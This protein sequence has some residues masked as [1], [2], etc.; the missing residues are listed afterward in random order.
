MS[1]QTIPQR[2][3]IITGM[4]CAA[5][6]RSVENDVK[7]LPFA[8]DA[9]VD[10]MSGALHVQGDVSDESIKSAV[11]ALGYDVGSGTEADE[12]GDGLLGFLGYVWSRPPTRMALFGVPFIIPGLFFGELFGREIVWAEWL[13]LVAAALAGAPVARSAWRA[14][15]RK[16]VDVHVLMTLAAVG[17]VAIGAW[18]EAGMVM[19]LYAVGVAVEGYVGERARASIRSL[20]L[21]SPEMA[22]RLRRAETPATAA[23]DANAL[24]TSRFTP[25]IVLKAS[26]QEDNVPEADSCCSTTAA[27]S[28]LDDDSTKSAIEAGGELIK[29]EALDVGDIIL[30][31][32]GAR[33]PV[34][35][36]VVAGHSGVDAAII[37]GESR[38][39]E[40]GPGDEVFAGSI[41]GE[42]SLEIEVTRPASD[43]T[44]RRV[45]RLVESAR[46]Q[47]APV[48][49]ALDRFA[50]W[51]TPAVVAVAAAVIVI[52]PL[53]FGQPLFDSGP[54]THG[55]LYRGLA[56]L[57]V[58]CPCALVLS[59]PASVAAAMSGAARSGILFK[60]GD[61]LEALAR[62]KAVAFDKT[63]TLTLGRPSVV[64]VRAADC[65]GEVT[66]NSKNGGVTVGADIVTT[67]VAEAAL[68]LDIALEMVASTPL[69]LCSACDE[70]VALAG[71][72]E[73]R[74]EHVL[75]RAVVN[76]SRER[77]VAGRYPTVE[78]VRAL[79]GQG[80]RGLVGEREVTVGSHR[81]FDDGVPHDSLVC[82]AAD[83]D[84]RMGA[85]PLLVSADGTYVGTITVADE[86]RPEARAVIEA[87]EKMGLG[88]IAMLTGDGPDAARRI[89]EVSGVSPDAVRASLMP[90]DKLDVIAALQR[91]VGSVA[92]IG[93]GV[94][95]APALAAADVGL[96]VG[97]GTDTA[98][99]T[100][101][102]ALMGDDLRQLP[103]AILRA[104]RAMRIVR[105]NIGISLGVKVVFGVLVLA[106]VGTLW[107]AVLADVGT[108]VIVT[109]NGLRAANVRGIKNAG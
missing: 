43:S 89:A 71:A 50:R 79:T 18:V 26:M 6:A 51:Y 97:Q 20:G 81:F 28:S 13:A 64:D 22:I 98:L 40:I 12:V 54:E 46:A 85:I 11:R 86:P 57:V 17:A 9:S 102:V 4:D 15:I 60:G 68:G 56:L 74:S 35:G 108:A 106:G 55:W 47:R 84:A 5:C 96:A 52:P 61:R 2:T 10:L 78:E 34:D 31:R 45:A 14:L 58:A 100:A 53:A 38:P 39:Q 30:A 19:V 90:A 66:A 21:K 8:V 73:S 36:Q 101:D 63:G 72:V 104:R 1:E 62:V 32:P 3:Y 99:E 41:N 83:C 70:L 49:R 82:E 7:R 77:G 59:T 29:A 103:E 91:E 105:E 37:T 48:E 80:V 23:G 33:L 24:G 75:A 94:N 92:M 44:M 16:N 76:A 27:D 65:F 25:D 42:G 109:L 67:A 69:A 107:M 87:L 93:D 88:P 95:D